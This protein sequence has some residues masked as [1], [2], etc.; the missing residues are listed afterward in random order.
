MSDTDRRNQVRRAQGIVLRKLRNEAGLSQEALAHKAGLDRSY[1]G[2][3]E[4]GHHSPGTDT[5]DKILT[6]LHVTFLRHGAEMTAALK[7][8]RH[9]QPNNDEV[10]N[11]K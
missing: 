5:L 9:E 4:R 11:G 8:L 6:A 1:I 7:K 10:A 2:M 3:V